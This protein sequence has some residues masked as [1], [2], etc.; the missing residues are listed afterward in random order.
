MSLGK[1]LLAL[2]CF[3][4]ILS[5]TLVVTLSVDIYVSVQFIVGSISLASIT[6]LY[7]VSLLSMYI[8]VT[9]F[10]FF[11]R[12]YSSKVMRKNIFHSMLY[13][14]V[15]IFILSLH[16][17]V[18][19]SFTQNALALSASPIPDNLSIVWQMTIARTILFAL[20]S[21]FITYL[22]CTT[23]ARYPNWLGA[24]NKLNS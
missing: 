20:G 2:L 5:V 14:V 8:G 24:C 19:R 7:A 1:F 10:T 9:L 22:T 3:Y 13:T 6:G 4:G 17:Y 23:P 11:D 18:Q 21:P 15:I 12:T 16:A